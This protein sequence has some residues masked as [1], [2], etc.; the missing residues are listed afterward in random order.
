MATK[1][2]VK[3]L[4][5]IDDAISTIDKNICDN[6]DNQTAIGCGLM[7]QNVLAQLRNLVEHVAIK[8]TSYDEDIE[9][10]YDTIKNAMKQLRGYGNDVRFISKFH[11]L[12][13]ISESHYTV[14]HDG[15]ERLLMGYQSY[16]I[17]IKHLMEKKY[18][19][20]ILHNIGDICV[21]KYSDV[22]EYYA[23]VAAAVDKI[24]ETSSGEF[25]V[26]RYYIQ[27]NKPFSINGK[28]YYEVTFTT[29]NSK[30]SK[31]DRITAFTDQEIFDNYAVKLQVDPSSIT[32]MGIEISI[33]IIR[34]WE[35]SIRPCEI[36]NF[37]RILGFNI[38]LDTQQTEYKKLMDF[39]TIQQYSLTDV[40]KMS[41]SVYLNSFVDAFRN[42]QT[43]HFCKVID[44]CRAIVSSDMP[45]SNVLLYLLYNLNSTIL[46][47][48]Y[49]P[50]ECG[51]LSN[52][53]LKNGCIPFDKM[54]FA[55]S[56]IQHNPTLFDLI[57]CIDIT[58]RDYELLA[59]SVKNNSEQNGSLF[60]PI[61]D[62]HNSDSIDEHI[63]RYN[64]ALY[65]KHSNR[66]LVK[67]KNYIYIKEYLDDFL[68]IV[69]NI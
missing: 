25:S 47:Q 62:L 67:Y 33:T 22:E 51:L 5:K 68:S 45:G 66:E 55:S 20:Y 63:T 61:G 32:L 23:K 40:V 21:G 35:V 17:K 43:N 65:D 69:N 14:G 44:R 36:K 42:C 56:L 53:N 24:V 58:N 54:P 49:K 16:L 26:D 6:I 39:L 3:D 19:I 7:S 4:L 29:V 38:D 52:L 41:E 30:A 64:S 60:M 46:K 13:Q 59:R 1:I 11:K 37:S 12:L 18:A 28:S 50:I 2:L 8:I 48:Q 9:P 27:K 57:D 31:F 10:N 34:K 15:S